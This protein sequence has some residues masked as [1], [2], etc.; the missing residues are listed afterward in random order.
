MAEPYK[1]NEFIKVNLSEI[2]ENKWYFHKFYIAE[3]VEIAFNTLSKSQLV[4]DLGPQLAKIG[5]VHIVKMIQTNHQDSSILSKMLES[6][7]ENPFVDALIAVGGRPGGGIM[8]TNYIDPKAEVFFNK[9][10]LTVESDSVGR[11]IGKEGIRIKS[12]KKLFGCEIKVESG[13][14]KEDEGITVFHLSDGHSIKVKLWRPPIGYK[15][16]G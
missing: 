3:R 4:A 8:S 7:G 5:S 15:A 9:I 11:W 13:L 16:Q 10:I 1:A 12:L 2:P 6:W 14:R